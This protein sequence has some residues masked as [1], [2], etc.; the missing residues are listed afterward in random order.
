MAFLS[1]EGNELEILPLI[2]DKR[3]D[4]EIV[5]NGKNKAINCILIWNDR[6]YKS[7]FFC[8]FLGDGSDT[9]YRDFI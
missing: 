8:G 4:R 7:A 5:I 6:D 3:L 1:S 2:L 9:G